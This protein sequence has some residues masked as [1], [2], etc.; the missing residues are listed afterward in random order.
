MFSK[1][2]DKKIVELNNPYRSPINR[3]ILDNYYY[4]TTTSVL[5]HICDIIIYSLAN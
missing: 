2:N 5:Q 4:S 1:V 3:I